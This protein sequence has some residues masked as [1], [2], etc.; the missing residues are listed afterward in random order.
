MTSNPIRRMAAGMNEKSSAFEGEI[1]YGPSSLG[2]KPSYGPGSNGSG[3]PSGWDE[4]SIGESVKPRRDTANAK[5]KLKSFEEIDFNFSEEWLIKKLLPLQGLVVT[6]GLPQAYKSFIV[7]DIALHVA[8][9]L[10]W[11]GRKTKQGA[12]VYIAAENSGGTK[13]RKVGFSQVHGAYLPKSVPFFL[14]E[15]APNL[16]TEKND[17]DELIASVEAYSV[18][19]ALI[20]VDTLAQTLCGG[21]ENGTGMAT[22]VNNATA[23]ANHFKCCVIAVHHVPLADDTR[24]RGHGSLHGGADGLFLTERNG[25]TLATTLTVQKLKDEESAIKAEIKLDRVVIGL[26][27]DYE[28]VS[29]LVVA[30]VEFGAGST[31]VNDKG[32]K[33][34]PEQRRLLM[35][36]VTQA[37]LEAGQD[38]FRSFSDGPLVR[39]VPEEDVRERY[40]ARIAERADPDENPD[41]LADRQRQAF[42]R[43]VASA[44]KA[45][46]LVARA[47]GGRRFLWLA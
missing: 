23:L 43:S 1:V 38:G 16:G 46:N 13:K 34:I 32:P 18:T 3:A 42:R 20:V 45:K 22:F 8:C 17:L 25:Q 29:T 14:I 10:N 47:E 5:F 21:E 40:Y 6:F 31:V 15:T 36:V 2:A 33:K 41:K 44:L 9:G 7:M 27:D 19:P 12:A 26:D 24:L 4:A 30:T 11:G 37:L 35:D 39:A 28:E